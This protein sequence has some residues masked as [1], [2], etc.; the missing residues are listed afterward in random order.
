MFRV[1]RIGLLFVF[2]LL[3]MLWACA[4][5]ETESVDGDD[6]PDRFAPPDGD[7]EGNP[8][9][10]DAECLPEPSDCGSFCL[11]SE[12]WNC[13]IETDEQ[14]CPRAVRT[15]ESCLPGF[16]EMA[17][18]LAVC[19]A[20]DGD[21]DSGE[22]EDEESAADGDEKSSPDGDEDA[23]T[24]GDSH[25]DGD[26]ETDGDE[27]I[28]ADA[29]RAFDDCGPEEICNF[30]LA[31]CERR[32]TFIETE[33]GLFS[34]HPESGASGDLLIVDGKRFFSSLWGSFSVQVWIGQTQ[35][36]A[37]GLATADENRILVPVPAGASGEIG[38]MCE[39]NIYLSGGDA[40]ARSSSGVLA[41]DGSTP[42]ASGLAGTSALSAGPY[43][44]G[45]LD[46]LNDALRLFYPAQ[47]G[48]I[49]R[50]AR[51]GEYPLIFLLHGNG[52]TYVNYEYLGQLLATWGFVS[53]MPAT[54]HNNEYSE[55][56]VAQL[57][58]LFQ[59][60][61]G[62]DLSSE[63]P[64]LQGVST[65]DAVGF[66]GHSRGCGRMQDLYMDHADV[67]AASTASVFLGPAN[68]ETLTPGL[69]LVMGA[70]E[71]GQSFTWNYNDFYE[72][73]DAPKWKVVIQGGNHSLFSDAKV[74]HA[75]DGVPSLLR[76]EQIEI[77]AFFVLPLF[78][79]AFGLDEPFS[80]NLDQPPVSTKYTFER[81]TE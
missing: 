60:F 25:P 40:F 17:E 74:Y 42:S 67:A 11:E 50:P 57:Y 63:H 5:D 43:A 28:P 38:V 24:D 66:L 21:L 77:V 8:V 68:T 49:R 54:E 30:A 76:K 71:D 44:A 36:V 33:S 18:G 9:D 59:R 22:R 23:A 79:R 34:F 51:P 56:V 52:A 13:R 70:T 14:G 27:E 78:Q 6:D 2:V 41:C 64:A 4:S 29:C 12:A 46:F 58:G 61:A 20:T 73:E 1:P 10:A 53:V 62:A 35:A 32:S 39:G 81:Q 3:S 48:S 47:C 45:Y 72:T 37:A 7:G 69:F 16:C 19:R 55:E 75:F 26:D 31:R 65:T 15:R 80:G